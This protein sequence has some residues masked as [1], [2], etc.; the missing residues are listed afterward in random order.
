VSERRDRPGLPYE[1]ALREKR[2][3]VVTYRKALPDI[4]S[5]DQSLPGRTG[6]NAFSSLL[7]I[8]WEDAGE[9]REFV[10]RETKGTE[11]IGVENR[12]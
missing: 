8:A 10:R 6:H 3:R 7:A 4:P 9:H 1:V 2:K 5:L 12:D 11:A